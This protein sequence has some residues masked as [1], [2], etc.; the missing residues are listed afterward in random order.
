[1]PY[2]KV[3]SHLHSFLSW[4]L[5]ARNIALWMQHIFAL[6]LQALPGKK[7]D[8]WQIEARKGW[9]TP[10]HMVKESVAE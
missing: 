2:R 6:L 1:M 8:R 4:F 10:G 7:G 3:I 9:L 5:E